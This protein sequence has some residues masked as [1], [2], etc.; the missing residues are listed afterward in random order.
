MFS[1]EEKLFLKASEN[2]SE[3][4]YNSLLIFYF[5]QGKYNLVEKYAKEAIKNETWGKV[6]YFQA[7][8]K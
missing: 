2:N 8:A 3:D 5:G 6:L 1:P 4:G 7:V